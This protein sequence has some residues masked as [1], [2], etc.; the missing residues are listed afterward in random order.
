MDE[1]GDP[2]PGTTITIEGSTKGVITDIDGN[3]S[4]EVQPMD[5]LVF[6]FI[7]LESQ[8][9]EVNNQTRMNVILKEK[10]SE[11]EEVMVG[12]FLF[13]M[14]RGLVVQPE[15]EAEHQVVGGVEVLEV[16]ADVDKRVAG[17]FYL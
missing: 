10:V 3:Y 7:G 8:T 6:S 2:V 9:I 16:I 12:M 13:V 14:P 5:K 4:I 17:G 1:N 11:L 15:A